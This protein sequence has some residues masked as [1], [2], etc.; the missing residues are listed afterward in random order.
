MPHSGG[1]AAVEAVRRAVADWLTS[2]GRT[3]ELAFFG[4]GAKTFGACALQRLGV[5][6]A[7]QDRLRDQFVREVS[8]ALVAR[9]GTCGGDAVK[10]HCG[11]V[12]PALTLYTALA[13]ELTT[14]QQ[15][16]L[17]GACA[18]DVIV[19]K[20]LLTHEGEVR[21]DFRHQHLLSGAHSL[22]PAVLDQLR[23]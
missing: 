5:I 20:E 1:L 23:A 21:V 22:S 9:A 17:Q 19:G 14:R 13:A 16:E 11:A 4:C 8:G 2:C 18:A 6:A 12:Q 10:L 3:E 15:L 7:E